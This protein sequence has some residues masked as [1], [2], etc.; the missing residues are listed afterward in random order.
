MKGFSLKNPDVLC[1]ARAA[2]EGWV[3]LFPEYS[4]EPMPWATCCLVAEKLI[5]NAKALA[6]PVLLDSAE[7]LVTQF[8]IYVRPDVAYSLSDHNVI[9]RDRAIDP[10]KDYLQACWTDSF[11]HGVWRA[12]K[13]EHSG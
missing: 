7:C 1:K 6:R 10:H 11:S 4:R 12:D 9:D 8:D 2:L 3:S 13:D 5:A